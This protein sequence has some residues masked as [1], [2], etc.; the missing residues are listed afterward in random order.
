VRATVRAS[1]N[2]FVATGALALV[3]TFTPPSMARAQAEAPS[4]TTAAAAE[5]YVATPGRTLLGTRLVDMPTPVTVG[6]RRWELL[7]AHRF[8]GTINHGGDGH[9]LWG[10]DGGAEV[11]I[12]AEYGITPWF[13]VSLHRASLQEDFE[14]AAKA[15]LWRESNGR[16]LSVAARVGVDR[17]GRKGVADATRPFAQLALS[18]DL[19]PHV[20]VLATPS[21]VSDTPRLEDAFNVPL[22]VSIR[23]ADHVRFEAEYVPK[24]RDFDDS[25]AAWHAGFS[26]TVGG[27]LFKVFLG[28]SKGTTVDQIV[29]GDSDGAFTSSDLR[30]GFNLVRYLPR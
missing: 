27:H 2:R 16:P 25:V 17:L 28:N 3:A 23:V 14:L 21:W 12:G 9:N 24:N 18:R 7:F 20:T 26:K 13:D 11:T 19:G 6:A 22:G 4:S 1:S 10:L 15:A 5:A 8:R 29:G 30:L